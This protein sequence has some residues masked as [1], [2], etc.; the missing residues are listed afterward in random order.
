MALIKCKE[1]GKEI[2]SN[3]TVCPSCGYKKINESEKASFGILA[4]CFL[5]P[6]VGIV[7]FII[8]ISNKPKYAKQCII[9]SLIPFA[10]IFIISIFGF[11]T[12]MF[13]GSSGSLTSVPIK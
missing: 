13:S 11:L 10:I 3:A 9:A 1:C 12:T 8:N 5:I 2:S 7:L 4:I 6:I